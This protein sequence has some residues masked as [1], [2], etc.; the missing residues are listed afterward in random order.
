MKT[1]IKIKGRIFSKSSFS[2]GATCVGV[3][4]EKNKVSVM[5]TNEK[6]TIVEFTNQ[7]WCAFLKGV[8]N[9]EFDIADDIEI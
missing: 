9:N 2:G 4:I 5:N 7:E 1:K 6:Q 8:K 3:S